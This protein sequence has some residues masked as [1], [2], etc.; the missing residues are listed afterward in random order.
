[1]VCPEKWDWYKVRKNL[2]KICCHYYKTSFLS[3][4]DHQERLVETVSPACLDRLA[5]LDKLVQSVLLGQPA[6]MGQW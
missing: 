6:W 3:A 5:T 2:L 1:M 4:Q